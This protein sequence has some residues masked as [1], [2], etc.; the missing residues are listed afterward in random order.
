MRSFVVL[1]ETGPI[2]TLTKCASITEDR[3]IGQFR[4]RGIDKFIAY[5]VPVKKVHEFYGVPFE[6]VAADIEKG[7]PMRVLDFNGPHIFSSF[8]FDELGKPTLY[9]NARA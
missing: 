8:S 5:E 1:T 2:L 6:M 4:R 7:R 9:E 3:L